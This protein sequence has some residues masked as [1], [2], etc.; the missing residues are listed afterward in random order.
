MS[1][2]LSSENFL[3][4]IQPHTSDSAARVAKFLR[5][6]GGAPTTALYMHREGG[7]LAT[8]PGHAG[9]FCYIHSYSYGDWS[10]YSIW[11]KHLSELIAYN[12]RT[13]T[14][15]HARHTRHQ[16]LQHSNVCTFPVAL[17]F[18]T[19]VIFVCIIITTP[20]AAMVNCYGY[21]CYWISKAALL[22]L[23][24]HKFVHLPL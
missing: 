6:G 19:M 8:M 11:L 20:S 13:I 17:K 7:Y 18:D 23:P 1:V 3:H 21:H 14:A 2:V 22:S 10:A 24:P 4:T 15:L 9:S 16:L 12:T 5:R